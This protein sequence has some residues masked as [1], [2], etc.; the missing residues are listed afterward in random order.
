VRVGNEKDSHRGSRVTGMR[1]AV[2]VRLTISHWK[3]AL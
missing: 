3:T 1:S 2:T